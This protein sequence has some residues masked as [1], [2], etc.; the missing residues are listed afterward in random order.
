MI[1]K[2]IFFNLNLALIKKT[3]FNE[4]L[5][6]LSKSFPNTML[7][8][9]MLKELQFKL[10][11]NY[12]G[13]IVLRKGLPKLGEPRALQKESAY[14]SKLIEAGTPPEV[15]SKIEQ[16]IDIGCRN[17]SYSRTLAEHFPNACL[18]GIEVDGLRRYWNLYRRIDLAE[19]YAQDLRNQ[20]RKAEVI[21]RDFRT[22][23]LPQMPLNPTLTL[24][25][26]FFPFVSEYPCLKWG[27]PSRFSD[28]SSIVSH[29]LQITKKSRNPQ[30]SPHWLSVHQGEWEAELARKIYL[31]NGL[32]MQESVLS[33]DSWSGLWPSTCENWVFSTYKE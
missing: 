28:F 16:V 10:R 6:Q 4:H 13:K 26:A 25:C 14:Y 8:N 9:T 30:L 29:S 27:L 7:L 15:A 21:A 5:Q 2:A 20:N 12:L 23:Q 32:S 3:L 17:W 33:P 11:Q 19:A 31:E 1:Y 18:I 24:F 22:C